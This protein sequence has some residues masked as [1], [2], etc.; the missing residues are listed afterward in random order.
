MSETSAPTKPLPRILFVDD[1][2]LLTRLGSEFLRKLGYDPV[3]A[4]CP[5]DALAKFQE[6]HFDAVITDL[7]MPRMSGIEL[8]RALQLIRPNLPIVLTTAFHQKLEGKHPSELGFSFLL[9]KPYNIGALM[10]A[11]ESALKSAEVPAQAPEA[12]TTVA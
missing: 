5:V 1:E 9:L 3:T 10:D 4:T 6:S 12:A 7:T 2:P 8:A 11:V